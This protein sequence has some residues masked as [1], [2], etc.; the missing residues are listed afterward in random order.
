[1]S[2]QCTKPKRKRDDSWFKDKV[3]LVQAQANGQVL[4]EEELSFLA[5]PGITN[6]QTTQTVTT[7]NAA[8][9]A[10]HLDTYDSDCDEISTAKVKLMENL[11]HYGS[12]ALAEVPNPDNVDTNMINPT[13]QAMS[14]FEQSN[15][16]SMNSPEPTLSSR[17]TIVEFPKELPKVS[18]VNMSL[19]KLKHHLAGFDVVVKENVLVITALK[20][21]LRKLKGKALADDSVSSHSIAL[22]MLKVNVEPLAHQ[23]LNNRTIHSDYLW[24]TQ[25][26][27]MILK[28]V[29]EQEKSKN[30]LN[31]S[32][33][34]AYTP[35]PVVTLVYSRKP[36]KSKTTDR[37]GKSKVL[38]YVSVN[39]KEPSKS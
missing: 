32:L 27:A 16:N 21:D 15:V 20:D 6:G 28:E 22:E 3:L 8:Y 17:P 9:Q 18:M 10:N 12:D 24:H 37:V 7:Y 23:L 14:S 30:L 35:K 26:Q 13:V 5:D 19:N 29:V 1:M 2:K 39:K 33:A 25:E 11:S 36:R 4:H 31:N 34:H 38:K